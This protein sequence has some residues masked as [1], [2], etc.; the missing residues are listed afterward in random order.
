MELKRKFAHLE[1]PQLGKNRDKI[2]RLS[3]SKTNFKE[4]KEVQHMKTSHAHL[5]NV[6]LA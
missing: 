6:F 2:L 4:D 3:Q 1:N 5:E